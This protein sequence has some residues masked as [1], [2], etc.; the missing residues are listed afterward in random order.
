MLTNLYKPRAYIWDF[1]VCASILGILNI[2][3]IPIKYFL[4]LCTN[5][6]GKK[7]PSENTNY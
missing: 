2:I 1:A 6:I 7:I 5:G 4:V 3:I